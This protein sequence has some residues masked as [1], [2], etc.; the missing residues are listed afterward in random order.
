[1]SIE[2]LGEVILYP[3]MTEKAVSLIEK[4]NMLTFIVRR[5]ASKPLIKKAIEELYQVK[6][7]KVRTLITP[8]GEKKAFVTLQPD[9]KASDVAIKL[10]I[11]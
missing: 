10:G 6:V 7:A 3:V 8:L 1:M 9:F 11:L 2:K 5:S 4:Q